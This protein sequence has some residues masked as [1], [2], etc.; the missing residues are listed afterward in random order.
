MI[1]YDYKHEMREMDM[2]RKRS[3]RLLEFTVTM[4]GIGTFVYLMMRIYVG[5]PK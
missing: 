4:T 1:P 3:R 5:G 2:H